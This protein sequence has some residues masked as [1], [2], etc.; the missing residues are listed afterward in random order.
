[1]HRKPSPRDARHRYPRPALWIGGGLAVAALVWMVIGVPALL[2]YPTDL[3]VSPQYEG[4]FTLLV[5]PATAAPLAEPVVMPLTVNRH[6][7]AIGDERGASRVVVG[8]H[9]PGGR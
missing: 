9:P 5:D 6:L 3:D 1:M 2:K 4:T 7:E 8:D